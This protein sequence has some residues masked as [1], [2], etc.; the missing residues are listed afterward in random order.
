[1]EF[2]TI[3]LLVMILAHA[4]YLWKSAQRED[5]DTVPLDPDA[6]SVESTSDGVVLNPNGRQP[7][8]IKGLDQ[9]TI[10]EVS[11]RF[12][13][14]ESPHS[15]RQNLG[16]LI[17]KNNATSPEVEAFLA[18]VKKEY[19]RRLEKELRREPCYEQWPQTDRD[20][21]VQE[22][23]E[24]AAHELPY[25]SVFQ[26]VT[27]LMSER[28]AEETADD[29][30]TQRFG[31]DAEGLQAYSRLCHRNI[32]LEARNRYELQTFERLAE[33]GL[34]VRGSDLSVETP[35]DRLRMKDIQRLLGD[36]APET[37]G[38]KADAIEYAAEVPGVRE[39]I[40]EEIPLSSTFQ[41][42]EPP[43]DVAAAAHAFTFASEYAGLIVTTLITEARTQR[44]TDGKRF[45]VIG[46]EDC[47][48]CNPYHNKEVTHSDPKSRPPH[49]I[50]CSCDFHALEF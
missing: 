22:A 12:Q 17:A 40:A 4:F 14:Q 11:E 5:R 23:H 15:L 47:C 7:I 25:C 10:D 49:H 48:I 21:F 34:A 46:E 26:D 20:D 33:N 3:A 32:P 8:H 45:E 29:A 44:Q 27:V 1:M 41:A 28:P 13:R 36:E 35:L 18:D 24:A 9:S 2:A 38:R 6:V 43:S 37:F 31:D 19:D 50:G 16:I 30:L 42:S 39:R